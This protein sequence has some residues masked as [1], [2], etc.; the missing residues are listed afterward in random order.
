MRLLG[1]V[2]AGG[3]SRRFGSDKALA[4]LDGRSLI[5]HAI[6]ALAAQ[7]DA[8]IVCGREWGDWVPDRPEP[9]LGPLG[10]INAA[11]H[12]AAARGF[13]AVLTVPCDVPGLPPDLAQ[14]LRPPGFVEDLPVTGLWP[15]SLA[16]GLDAFLAGTQDRSMR[17]WTRSIGA[18]PLRL[19][20]PL[21][22]INRPED[23]EKLG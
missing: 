11:L 8:V 1:A 17:A 20:V 3:Q 23:L 9:G 6:A 19:D 4:L 13:D 5:E 14:R 15:A 12:A 16:A 7:V 10:G 22:N 18:V 21:P 2:L